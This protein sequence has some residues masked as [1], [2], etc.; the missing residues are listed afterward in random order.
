MNHAS[1]ARQ[2]WTQ[3]TTCDQAEGRNL[4]AHLDLC[5]S[6][7]TQKISHNRLRIVTPLRR[8]TLLAVQA[9]GDPAFNSGEAARSHHKRCLIN[10]GAACTRH[11]DAL[12]GKRLLLQWSAP[13]LS[14]AVLPAHTACTS[15]SFPMLAG[16]KPTLALHACTCRASSGGFG[17]VGRF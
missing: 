15:G 7:V 6:F 2:R 1:C 10:G 16:S 8:R 11:D 13:L 4:S 14:L 5:V 9:I 12:L 17:A 3:I